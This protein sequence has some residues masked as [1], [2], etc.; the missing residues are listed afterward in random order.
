MNITAEKEKPTTPITKMHLPNP[1]EP[2]HPNQS[3]PKLKARK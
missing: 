1:L 2:H 3:Q